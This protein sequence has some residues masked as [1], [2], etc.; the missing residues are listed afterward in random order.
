VA[1]TLAAR[2]VALQGWS[3]LGFARNG[4]YARERLGVSLR[5][6]QEW[7]RVGAGL[8]E[9]PALE[10]AL[11][12][13][14]LPWSKLRLLARFLS[15]R[16][17]TEDERAWIAYAAGVSVKKLEHEL[18]AVD[19]GALE[20]GACERVAFVA[21]DEANNANNANNE[22]ECRVRI[23]VPTPLAFKWQRTKNLA[24]K[25]DGT[26]LSAGEALE[27]VTAE[28]LAALPVVQPGA[29]EEIPGD[30]GNHGA[31]S[32]M[33]VDGLGNFERE[34]P[35][36]IVGM[37]GSADQNDDRPGLSIATGP[38]FLPTSSPALLPP[39]LGPL[40]EDLDSADAFEVDARLRRVIRLE[41][42]LDAQLA[43]LIRRVTSPEYEWSD[44]YR[45]KATLA[46]E[47]LGMSPSKLRALLR[48]ERLGDV[49][50][51]VREAYRD[52]ELSWGRAQALAPLI[53][54]DAE[55]SPGSDWRAEW[56]RFATTVTGQRLEE[57]VARARFLREADYRAFEAHREDP[58]WFAASPDRKR[59]ENENTETEAERQ[60]CARPTDLLGG[61]RITIR[62]ASDVARLFEAV[63]CTL[64]RAIEREMG[65]LPNEA[66][67]F[68]AMIDHALMSW[69]A[70]DRELRR[71]MSK[72]YY[73]VLD[74]DDWRCVFPGCSSRKNLHV[75]HIR[76]RSNGGGDKPENLT[77]LCAFHHLR[78][79]H[80][81]TVRVRGAAPDGLLFELGLREGREPLAR[82]R[83]GA[84]PGR[85]VN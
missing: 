58:A 14:R 53:D 16:V 5:S 66:E 84:P 55:G 44:Q 7:A 68:E 20:A 49:C 12:S 32:S 22:A 51:S 30:D 82:Y 37:P 65:R 36:E 72:K 47:C 42:R 25:V 40:L 10:A 45:S 77:T 71:R 59:N 11:L 76:F 60:K 26:S 13:G 3:R 81:G 75:H 78:G 17:S 18:R 62:V 39:F 57:T 21:E 38:S 33:I 74:R 43:P 85:A 69:G 35:G 15:T 8:A 19:R 2:W 28:V 50:P 46:R 70:E 83:S 1:V 56:V 67:A 31:I 54:S 4:D 48:V 27:R 6:L 9:R 79:V 73:A 23:S 61:V 64:R 52:G 29:L 41:Q 24:A 34:D 80:G 63:M